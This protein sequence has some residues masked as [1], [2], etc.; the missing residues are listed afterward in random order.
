M[1]RRYGRAPKGERVIGAVPQNYG[2]N[3]TMLAAL[4]SQGVE[5]RRCFQILKSSQGSSIVW[6]LV[7]I[8]LFGSNT[9]PPSLH[10]S[11]AGIGQ[12]LAAATIDRYKPEF[13]NL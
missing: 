4:G 13:F 3:V 7:K 10:L 5:A 8:P 12:I 11:V 6:L 1:T 2:A 9:S